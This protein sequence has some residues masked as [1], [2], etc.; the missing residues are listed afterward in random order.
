[1]RMLKKVGNSQDSILS[2]AL[3]SKQ[4]DFGFTGG[5]KEQFQAA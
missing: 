4:L 1:M 3:P 2:V 5:R